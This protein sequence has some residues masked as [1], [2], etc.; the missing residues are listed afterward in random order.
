LLISDDGYVDEQN[1]T[2]R[3]I[4]TY[5]F[6]DTSYEVDHKNISI[7]SLGLNDSESLDIEIT[8]V[9]GRLLAT[10]G[11]KLVAV[12]LNNPSNSW[13]LTQSSLINSTNHDYAYASAN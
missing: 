5:R 8:E 2:Q 10:D 9:D 13:I 12:D 4:V 7:A 3:V 1:T 11:V 6:N